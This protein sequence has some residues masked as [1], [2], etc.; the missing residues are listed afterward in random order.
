M[1]H[2]EEF[3]FHLLACG[4]QTHSHNLEGH[5][6]NQKNT[7]RG[8]H[9]VFVK[10]QTTCVRFDRYFSLRMKILC[11]PRKPLLWW[12]LLRRTFEKDTSRITMITFPAYASRSVLTRYCLNAK[13][14]DAEESLT[15]FVP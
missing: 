13:N 14:T 10:N 2:T 1:V 5:K 7:N 9:P 4:R 3:W 15:P 6:A 12:F 8:L 11:K